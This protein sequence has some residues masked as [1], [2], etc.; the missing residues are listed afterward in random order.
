MIEKIFTDA[1]THRAWTSEGVSDEQ[2]HALYE[3]AKLGPT[4]GNSFP[5]RL[6]FVRTPEAKERLKPC[7]DEGNV[8]K[9]MTAPV[10][11]IV[12]YDLDFHKHMH[13]LNP[14]FK[15][16]FGDEKAREAQASMNAAM[17]G[18][19]LII[20]ARAV[21]LDCGPMGGFNRKAVDAAFFTDTSLRS[22]FLL[23]LGHGDASKLRPRL[24]RLTFD[25]A[26]K[27]I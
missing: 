7:L 25:E 24:E 5:M 26:A 4:A 15:G 8:E 17:Q 20:A 22:L 11:A 18:A 6:V 10:T 14:H 2:L 23:N 9:T 16:D 13:K 21:G 27:I 12:A 3:L 1:R 19:Y